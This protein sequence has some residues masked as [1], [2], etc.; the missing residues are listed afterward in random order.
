MS[1]RADL[2]FTIKTDASSVKA[3]VS[4]TERE[5]ARLEGIT[6][7]AA[8]KER[9]LSTKTGVNAYLARGELRASPE[10]RAAREQ[11][12]EAKRAAQEKRAIL[13]Q[14]MAMVRARD[15]FL[16]A[17]RRGQI[18]H[19]AESIR[20]RRAAAKVDADTT[21]LVRITER[22]AMK[23][24]GQQLLSGDVRGVRRSAVEL[25]G[26]WPVAVGVGGALA[27]GAALREAKKAMDLGDAIADGAKRMGVGVVAFQEL[28]YAG[29]NAGVAAS[30]FELAWKKLS[31]QIESGEDPFK[32]LGISAK[33]LK[34]LDPAEAILK[35]TAAINKIQDPSRRTA[36]FTS[37]FGKKGSALG[38]IGGT[39]EAIKRGRKTGAIIGEGDIEALDQA[40]DKWEQIGASIKGVSATYIATLLRDT[41]EWNVDLE[42]TAKKWGDI[43]RFIIAAGKDTAN[44]MGSFDPSK[45]SAL[46]NELKRQR[47]FNPEQEDEAARYR[48]RERRKLAREE[49]KII[50]QEDAKATAM[51][52][53]AE[54]T[55]ELRNATE[56][57][58]DTLKD[59]SKEFAA[60]GLTIENR[61]RAEEKARKDFEANDPLEKAKAERDK[62][63]KGILESM[64][65]PEQARMKTMLAGKMAGLNKSQ[66]DALKEKADREYEDATGITQKR[67]ARSAL[68]AS[69]MTPEEQ[70]GAA[71]NEGK[72]LNLDPES[73]A[74]LVAQE[75]KKL[76]DINAEKMRPLTDFIESLAE[77]FKQAGETI[78]GDIST[79]LDEFNEKMRTLGSALSGG[80]IT[81]EEAAK[82]EY[83]YRDDLYQS[84]KSAY[85][86]S[87]Q[88]QLEK[89]QQDAF[90]TAQ[91]RLGDIGQNQYLDSLF[92]KSA[93]SGGVGGTTRDIGGELAKSRGMN[94]A[95]AQKQ[96]VDIQ[97]QI[98]SVM[99]DYFRQIP[100][101][102]MYGAGAF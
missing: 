76:A 17:S 78:R 88:G 92:P 96:A 72:R 23:K 51:E 58:S 5:L 26:T 84:Q 15:S 52:N 40:K 89:Q 21:A 20:S 79:P 66:M 62:S 29:L 63:R 94:Q 8:L 60:G 87:P 47:D 37:L 35:T 99:M 61:K 39:D 54:R 24:A 101:Q 80:A 69:L 45:G 1:N 98:L 14:E 56:K 85:A 6:A 97:R 86:T 102:R 48:A 100:A 49:Q 28:E 19:D 32:K 13:E 57:Y 50:E 90:K 9:A 4:Q 74:R 3:G 73:Q 67:E 2:L 30:D 64:E 33:E 42:H 65:T 82:A 7:R 95:D 77:K 11:V 38:A 41:G 53:G 36:A 27:G 70:R 18:R 22:N 46:V 55:K 68:K 81:A 34:G 83:K 93:M 71:I 31:K 16:G 91:D 75:D 10:I 59:I 44:L 43:T 12:A 25:L